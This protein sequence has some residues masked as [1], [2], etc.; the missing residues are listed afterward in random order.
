[1]TAGESHGAGLV[2]IMEGFPA[3]F[4]VDMDR[5]NR[6]LA[7]RQKGYGRGERMKIEQDTAEILAGII[8]GE[9]YGAPLSL[10]IRNRDDRKLPD[11]PGEPTFVPRPGHVDLAGSIKYDIKD[12]KR[13][14][15]RASART[16]AITV[17]FGSVARQFLEYFGIQIAAAVIQ[18]GNAK[19]PPPEGSLETVINAVEE[20]PVRCAD[21]ESAGHMMTLIDRARNEGETLGGIIYVIVE[22][23]PVGLGSFAHPDRKLDGRLAQALMSIPAIKGVEIGDGFDLAECMGSAAHDEISGEGRF[24]RKTNRAGGLEGGVSNGER[25]IV[26]AAM[27]PIPTVRKGLSS[28]NV[29]TGEE[30]IADYV[31]SDVCAVPAASVVA[32][33]ATALII[34]D[35]FLEK[36]AGD[37]IKEVER[38]F[39]GY[40]QASARHGIEQ[41]AD[42]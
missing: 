10:M 39:Q 2:G 28:V 17:A 13:A 36:F 18:I 11:N 37:T 22:G 6:D 20:S 16:T 33:S 34:L 26:K 1:L 8:G 27:K 19:A 41:R 30:V 25:I 32:E 7:R 12:L 31:R 38:S 15:E 4:T 21:S 14:A 3:G 42:S 29:L 23:A 5:I 35:A 40:L 9:T 24:R